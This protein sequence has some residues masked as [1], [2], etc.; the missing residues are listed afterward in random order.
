MDSPHPV[1]IFDGHCVLCN[2]AVDFIIRRD[3]D[4]H[5]LFAPSQSSAGQDLLQRFD[6]INQSAATVILIHGDTALLRSDAALRIARSLSGGWPLLAGFRI[7]PRCLRDGVYRFIARHR[8]RC[9]G[10]RAEC[11][12]PSDEE[13]ARFLD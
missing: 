5:F 7:L 3:P 12:V 8:Y 10:R 6:L 2:A 11:R 9:F 4:G 1:V 13:K